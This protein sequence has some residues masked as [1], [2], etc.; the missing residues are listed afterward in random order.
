MNGS[1][2]PAY[3]FNIADRMALSA[4]EFQ[5]RDLTVDSLVD[6][7]GTVHILD[8]DVL[9]ADLP[10]EMQCYS[11]KAI[12][13]GLTHKRDIIVEAYSLVTKYIP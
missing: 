11:L 13:H 4:S 1:R 6:A 9:P 2:D 3:Y 10:A 5:R 8:E 12:A 7:A